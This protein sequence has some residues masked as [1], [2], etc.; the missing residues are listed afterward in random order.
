MKNLKY[1]AGIAVLGAAGIAHAQWD[2][3][4]IDPN[5]TAPFS[6][7][8]GTTGLIDE[9]V[10]ISVGVSGTVTYGGTAGP[11]YNPAV[12]MT[13]AGSFAFGAGTTG[14]VQTD[15]D[16]LMAYTFGWIG[17]PVGDF[18]YARLVVG[19][20]DGLANSMPI[21]ASGYRITYTGASKR[22][23][24][25][26]WD[27]TVNSVAVEV[28]LQY[29]II[30]DAVRMR[31]R[32]FNLS[33]APTMIGMR[34]GMTPAMHFQNGIVDATGYNMANWP[35]G[36]N[37][38]PFG[39]KFIDGYTGFSVVPTL[40]PMRTEKKFVLSN[41]NYPAYIKTLFGQQDNVGLRV[42]NFATD[43]VNDADATDLCIFA[44]RRYF[45]GQGILSNSDDG[46]RTMSTNLFG[47][48]T[49]LVT[50]N[51]IPISNPAILQEFPQKS[52]DGNGGFRDIVHY[53]RG[54]FTRGFYIDPYTLLLDAPTVINYQGSVTDGT[55][56]PNPFPVQA[57]FDNQYADIDKEIDVHDVRFTLDLPHGLSFDPSDPDFANAEQDPTTG[58]W[59][60]VKTLG[61]IGANQIA[62]V[63]W[64][65][66]SDG[67]TYGDLPIKV[68][69]E[70]IPGPTRSFTQ[71]IRV[72]STPTY[73]F[74]PGSNL[75][76][77][78][79]KLGDSSLDS[80]LGLLTGRDY[81]AYA[82]DADLRGYVPTTSIQRGQ[83]LWIVPT[84]DLGT[85]TLNNAAFPTDVDTG[86]LLISLK[87]GWNL[88]GNPYNYPIQL[89]QI[90]GVAEDAPEN[91]LTWHQLVQNGF[92]NSSLSYW[93]ADA[94]LPDG[95]SYQY[96]SDESDSM[97]PHVG[98]WIFVNTFG[99]VRLSM[100]ALYQEQLITSAR[101][102]NPVWKNSDRQW[103]LQLSARST[104]GFDSTNYV[105]VTTDA[106]KAQAL[107]IPKPPMSPTGKLELA[108]V[109]PNAKSS[110]RLAQEF[111]DRVAK[112]DW[113]LQVNAKEAG[114][115][116]VTW[117]NAGSLPRNVRFVLTD[118]V[119]G[120]KFDLRSTSGYTFKMAQPGT[121]E[122]TLSMVPGGS[123]RPVI[124]DVEVTRSGRDVSGPV[125]ISYS[126]SADALVSVRIL[127]ANGKEVYQVSRGRSDGTGQNSVTWMLRDSAN[128]AV[129]PGTYKVEIMAETPTG[130]RVRKIVPVNVIR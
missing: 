123:L 121:R 33:T 1:F 31:W 41:P 87:K 126:L 83:G 98:Y 4:C 81:V 70:P 2:F 118:P 37:Q 105:G 11:C 58:D 5:N 56:E 9:L 53:I 69:A 44:N 65:V 114:D 90:V 10:G 75:I 24:V 89:G 60:I 17:E 55:Q 3:E 117:P 13:A 38:N 99:A 79:Y 39:G 54:N 8:Y 120:Q 116:T 29:R 36:T 72:A 101:T 100:P 82:W 128:R 66:V 21:G 73:T 112:K 122:L 35:T 25:A 64:K 23:G 48:P 77:I 40:K 7:D 61:V 94:S 52:V 49:G 47:D 18:T 15:K 63:N 62:G 108:V 51:D 107:E 93:Q 91:A 80:T 68:T 111:T 28:E 57:W 129:A 76:S 130:E 95:G 46:N 85:I 127:A 16:D 86:G 78:P 50:E 30:G 115:V 104:H 26:I 102:P 42:D 71:T 12:T 45:P 103:R 19:T 6:A 88:I 32:C 113:Q 43:G 125:T 59:K 110:S 84:N 67:K 22:Y 20:G 106:K 124:G 27:N 92:V 96:I 14:S 34:W 74:N 97:T 109:D 119:S